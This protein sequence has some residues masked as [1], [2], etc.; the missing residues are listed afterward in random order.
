MGKVADGKRNRQPDA[1]PML[2]K[3]GHLVNQRRAALL[4]KSGKGHHDRM[5]EDIDQSAVDETEEDRA[6]DQNV[7]PAARDVVHA[8]GAKSDDEVEDNPQ[9]RCLSASTVRLHAKDAAGDGL[10]DEN[11]FLRTVNHNGVNQVD[12]ADNESA[13]KDGGNR[14]RGRG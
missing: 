13:N 2:D 7:E 14:P 8:C 1:E 11:G 4:G 10:R 6:V 9:C 3:F 5:H 12:Y